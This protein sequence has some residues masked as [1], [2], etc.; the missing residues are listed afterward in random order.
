MARTPAQNAVVE[1][2]LQAIL[3]ELSKLQENSAHF[4]AAIATLQTQMSQVIAN[5]EE[6]KEA[7]YGNGKP[8]LKADLTDLQERV[9]KVEEKHAQ[10]GRL[11]AEKAEE[12]KAEVAE[13]RKFRWGILAAVALASLDLLFRLLGWK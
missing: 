8:G 5:Q 4:A 10:E 13:W 6:L 11:A 12:K 1:G 2:V 9:G 7:V 3:P